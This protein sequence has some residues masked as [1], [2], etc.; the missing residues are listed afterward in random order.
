VFGVP[1]P[2]W[3]EAVT[4][5]VVL[6]PGGEA[7]AEELTRFARE[8]LAGFKAPKSVLIVDALPKNASGKVLKR[9]LRTSLVSTSADQ[10]KGSR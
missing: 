6:R 8:H 2:T 5:V 3:I 7:D 10:G 9:E 4:A 1:H